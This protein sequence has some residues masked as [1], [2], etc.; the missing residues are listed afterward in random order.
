M[1]HH[2]DRPTRA[3]VSGPDNTRIGR[4]GRIIGGCERNPENSP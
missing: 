2:Y 4:I 3:A 1:V